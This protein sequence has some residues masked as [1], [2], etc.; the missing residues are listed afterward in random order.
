MFGSL[1]WS[2]LQQLW[3]LIVAVVGSLFVF[4]TFVQG[5]QT[6]ILTLPGTE[7]EKTLMVNSLGR[8]WELTFT[9]L[10]LFGGAFYASFPLFYA[11]S[12]GGA[13]WVWIAILFT[14]IIQAVSYEY[15]KKPNNFLGK[16]TYEVF[17]FVNGSVGILLIGAAIG[18]FFTG[19]NFTLNEYNLVKWTHPLRGLEAAFSLFNLSFGLFLVFLARTLGALYLANNLAHESLVAR[20]KNSSFNNLLCAL[21][22]LL[23]V[24]IS[25]VLMDGYAVNPADGT[26]TMEANKYLNNLLQMP[27]NLILLLAGLVL[28]VLGVV[29]NRFTASV[30]GIWPSGLGTVL[31]CLAVFFLAGYNNTSFYPSKVDLGSSLTIYNASSSHYTLTAM[32]YVALLV[33]F[34]LAYITWVWRQMDSKKLTVEELAAD[35]KSY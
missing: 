29:I 9:T 35:K 27:L 5:G 7:D 31:T 24:L 21:P 23:Y 28:V 25:L 4:L 18:T 8:K 16:K 10:V 12:F 14:F 26:V 11:S 6:L 1:D 20:L 22:F 32:S 30:R 34:V 17:M 13:Y 19:S 2:T 3:W 33:P 15:R